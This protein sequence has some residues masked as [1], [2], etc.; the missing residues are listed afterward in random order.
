M[1]ELTIA[2]QADA[3][4][5]ELQDAIDTIPRYSSRT[6]YLTAR[7]G[8][9]LARMVGELARRGEQQPESAVDV[10]LKH[11][12][13]FFNGGESRCGCGGRV[14]DGRDWAEHVNRMLG[15]TQ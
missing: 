2:E 13:P 6:P 5:A 14:R 7:A 8:I 11:Q 15:G 4:V 9:S 10:L 1:T 3:L 12:G